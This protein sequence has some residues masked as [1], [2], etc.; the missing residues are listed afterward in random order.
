[1]KFTKIHFRVHLHA[2]CSPY[3]L[4]AVD[5]MYV[6]MIITWKALQNLNPLYIFFAVNIR[7]VSVT[8]LV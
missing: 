2:L 1:M 8:Y 6:R 4:C 5:V 7:S 3:T